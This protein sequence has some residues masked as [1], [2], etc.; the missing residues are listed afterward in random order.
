M[1]RTI[2]RTI[3]FAALAAGAAWGQLNVNCTLATGPVEVN[4]PYTVGCTVAGGTGS[5]TWQIG[6]QGTN[7]PDGLTLM[8]SGANATVSGT[9]TTPA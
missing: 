5:Y 1:R 8:P 2:A 7:L 3:L 9:P 6:P 4:V